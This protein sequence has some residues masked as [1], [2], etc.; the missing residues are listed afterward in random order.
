MCARLGDG[1]ADG[2]CGTLIHVLWSVG[3]T[4]G[5]DEGGGGGACSAGSTT[6][7]PASLE[8]RRSG[9]MPLR[10]ARV[11]EACLLASGRPAIVASPFTLGAVRGGGDGGEDG[12]LLRRRPAMGEGA[13]GAS[14]WTSTGSHACDAGTNPVVGGEDSSRDKEHRTTGT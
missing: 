14:M 4:S 2:P 11:P 13:R 1:V 5:E 8:K 6:A 10:V 9:G 3:L 12:D 7:S